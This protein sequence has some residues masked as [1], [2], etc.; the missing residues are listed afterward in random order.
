[1]RCYICDYSDNG[2]QSSYYL[3]L[4]HKEQGKNHKV[5]FVDGKYVCDACLRASSYNVSQ[6][7]RI[8]EPT[9]PDNYRNDIKRLLRE[10][11]EDLPSLYR[12]LDV[13]GLPHDPEHS[14]TLH[15]KILDNV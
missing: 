5:K 9:N 8:S 13:D 3:S 7:K 4:S 6:L 1:M 14:H 11:K 2:V 12:K 10:F 15:H